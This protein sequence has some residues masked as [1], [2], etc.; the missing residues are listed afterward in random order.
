MSNDKRTKLK[1]RVGSGG[2]KWG[3]KEV[4]GRNKCFGQK[5]VK[6]KLRTLN[7]HSCSKVNDTDGGICLEMVL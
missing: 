4:R 7:P 3:T 6:I 1:G 5:K 2:R